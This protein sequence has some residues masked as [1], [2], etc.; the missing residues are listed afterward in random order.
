MSRQ[1]K[2]SWLKFV[3]NPK[4][5][6]SNLHAIQKVRNPSARPIS[7]TSAQIRL[8]NLQFI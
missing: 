4:S 1:S 3:D 8:L 7:F 2:A 5:R 6:G